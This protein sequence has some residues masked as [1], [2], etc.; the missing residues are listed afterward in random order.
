MDQL[1]YIAVGC[2]LVLVVL[3]LRRISIALAIHSVDRVDWSKIRLPTFGW[4]MSAW[5]PRTKKLGAIEYRGSRCAGV[6][7]YF[8]HCHEGHRT[9]LYQGGV[10]EDSAADAARKNTGSQTCPTPDYTPS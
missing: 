5:A 9:R 7:W 2:V 10:G 8:V 1:G 4:R 3:V 6:D